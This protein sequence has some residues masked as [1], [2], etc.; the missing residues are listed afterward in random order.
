MKNLFYLSL[1]CVFIACGGGTE[2]AP[3]E[4]VPANAAP[5]AIVADLGCK[6]EGGKCLG[7]HS[8]CAV[9]EETEATEDATEEVND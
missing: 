1:I 3:A 7:D 2:E 8:C 9:S 4:A 5:E 6:T